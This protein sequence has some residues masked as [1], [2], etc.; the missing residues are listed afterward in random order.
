MSME[1][2]WVRTETGG[3]V[4]ADQIIAL[5]PLKGP[6]GDQAVRVIAVGIDGA[7]TVGGTTDVAVRDAL[8]K[9]LLA[10][11][12]QGCPDDVVWVELETHADGPSTW[13]TSVDRASDPG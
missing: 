5:A 4:R 12:S 2:V 10:A 7:L 9:V 6:R 3:A 1:R 13:V 11:A 8:P